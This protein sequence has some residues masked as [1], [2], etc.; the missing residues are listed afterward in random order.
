[1]DALF[2]DQRMESSDFNR[3]KATGSQP[4]ACWDDSIFRG[5]IYS[6]SSAG[7]LRMTIFYSELQ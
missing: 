5:F 6:D 1:M 7:A 3:Y 2:T 4:Q